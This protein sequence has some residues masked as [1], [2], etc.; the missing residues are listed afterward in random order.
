MIAKIVQDDPSTRQVN[1]FL[2]RGGSSVTVNYGR[3]FFSLKPKAERQNQ[4]GIMEYVGRMRKKLSGIP[5][6]RAFPVPLQNLRVGGR[7]S[8]SQYQYTLQGSDFNELQDWSVKMEERMRKVPGLL[9]VTSDL[10]VRS[11]QLFIDIDRDKAAALG[12]TTDAL[13]N[14]LFTAFG[15]RQVATIY[16]ATNNY[17]VLLEFAP[18]YRADPNA[19]SQL[20][21]RSLSGDLVPLQA[22][23]TVRQLAGPL[24]INH[25]GAGPSVTISFNLPPNLPLGVAVERVQAVER[26]MAMPPSIT[27]GFAGTAQAFQQSL[28]GQGLLLLAAI[29]VMY[30]VLGVLYESFVHPITILSGLPSA[31]LGA[32]LTLMWFGLDLSVIAII[33]V[34]MLIGIVKKNAIMMVDRA[35]EWRREHPELSPQEAIYDACLVRFRPIMMTTMAAVFGVLPIALGHGAGSEL[36]RP[37]GVAVVGGLVVSQLLTLY[38][39]P[40]VYVYL[41]TAR[42]WFANRGQKPAPVKV[43]RL[44]RAATAAIHG[45]T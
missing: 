40:V 7:F 22:F 45:G 33:G 27:T 9:D 28:Q 36:R 39:T 15:S 21:V 16:A 12:V 18:K 23:T 6:M 30:V 14:S 19:L 34:V 41:E 17:Q 29:F 5:G 35:L 37:L 1:S 2:G 38:I 10:Q 32:I 4:E 25:Q 26:E 3:L 20:Y 43:P 24:S 42:D 44:M 8:K 13:R 11:P 31:G